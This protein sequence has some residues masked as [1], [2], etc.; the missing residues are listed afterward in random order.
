ML[1]VQFR[2]SVKQKIVYHISVIKHN[3]ENVRSR[4]LLFRAPVVL[5]QLFTSF[6][7]CNNLSR[8]G[9]CNTKVKCVFKLLRAKPLF[10]LNGAFAK[11]RFT[12]I[13]LRGLIVLFNGIFSHE[14]I[15]S[16]PEKLPWH[17]IL[18]KTFL[19]QVPYRGRR[20]FQFSPGLTLIVQ[21]NK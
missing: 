3:T 8:R 2:A 16:Y 1:H 14:K 19:R 12:L 18:D 7:V 10:L 11:Y 15:Y 9:E 4:Y 17:S 13:K 5:I 20:E 6:D 21:M